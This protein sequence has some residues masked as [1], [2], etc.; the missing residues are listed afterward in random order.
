MITCYSLITALIV[1]TWIEYMSQGV[2]RRIIIKFYRIPA[3]VAVDCIFICVILA[4]AFLCIR[5]PPQ[6]PMSAVVA[7]LNLAAIMGKHFQDRSTGYAIHTPMYQWRNKKVRYIRTWLM[8]LFLSY[9]AY[10]LY[11]LLDFAI[12]TCTQKV[13]IA[14]G[15]QNL[16]LTMEDIWFLVSCWQVVRTAFQALG[17]PYEIFGA[18]GRESLDWEVDVLGTS[19]RR[20]LYLFSDTSRPFQT[21]TQRYQTSKSSSYEP[22]ATTLRASKLHRKRAVSPKIMQPL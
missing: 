11:T 9:S 20:P 3:V 6:H 14:I 19:E 8:F 16:P 12:V 18:H 22:P 4:T 10:C 13:L 17:I 21:V 15:V 2:P 5:S 1:T 7:V